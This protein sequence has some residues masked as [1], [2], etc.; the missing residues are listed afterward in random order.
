MEIG[1][2]T[3]EQRPLSDLPD[4]LIEFGGDD[5]WVDWKGDQ[6]VSGAVVLG[7]QVIVWQDDPLTDQGKQDIAEYVRMRLE[8]LDKEDEDEDEE[9]K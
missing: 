5:Q 3:F 4:D 6:V 8:L 2:F 7:D 1:E 9:E